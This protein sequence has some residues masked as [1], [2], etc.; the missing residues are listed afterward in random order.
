MKSIRTKI[1]FCVTSSFILLFLLILISVQFEMNQ[2]VVPLS[3]N[4]TGQIVN[5]KGENI[6]N[7]L[8]E[9]VR[10]VETLSQN[11]SYF[12]LDIDESLTY[13]RSIKSNTDNIYES[14]GIIDKD[15]VAWI[16]NGASFSIKDREYYDRILK[17]D[18]D[19]VISEPISSYAND[20]NIVVILHRVDFEGSSE[21]AYVSTAVSIDV[22]NRTASQI[23][24][25]DGEGRI[26]NKYGDYIDSSISGNHLDYG[27]ETISFQSEIDT[28]PGWSI[29]FNV[30]ESILT[31]GMKKIQHQAIVIASIVGVSLSIILVF[32]S[33]SIV[34]PLKNL[35]SLMK[36]VENGDTSVRYS[37]VSDDEI[38]MLGISFNEMLSELKQ[39]KFEKNEMELLLMQEQVKPHFLYNALDTIRWS[40]EDDASQ[41]SELIHALSTYFRVGFSKGKKN[42]TL[43]EELDHVESYLQIQSARFE[44]LL[45][46]EICYDEHL[47]NQRIP[48]IIIQPLVENSIAH[49]FSEL[50]KKELRIV[51][52]IFSRD[53]NL[54]ICIKDNGVGI[55][56]DKLNKIKLALEKD[57]KPGQD[58]GF[59][60]YGANH[61]IKLVYGDPYG[62][63]INQSNGWTI[64]ELMLPLEEGDGFFV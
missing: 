14:L 23:F 40:A 20:E 58:I 46:Y 18:D 25:Y 45:K 22:I 8:S 57:S 54:I 6:S 50:V 11:I 4:L 24:L 1:I 64:V 48:K 62:L 43:E 37:P 41:A 30:S 10:D 13:L 31:E 2:S 32:L 36:D 19:F 21:I 38:N 61:R 47:I 12:Q 49:G 16:T 51:I 7:W 15:G 9:R 29:V 59:G 28:S 35:Q 56:D 63:F 53:N 27:R 26:I 3:K 52:E 60:L 55:P 39:M 44:D 42:V 5:A 17:T 34:R 33:R